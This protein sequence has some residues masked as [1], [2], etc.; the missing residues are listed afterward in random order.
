MESPDTRAYM[1]PLSGRRSAGA[2]VKK[3]LSGVVHRAMAEDN[4]RSLDTIDSGAFGASSIA[5]IGQLSILTADTAWSRAW[6]EDEVGLRHVRTHRREPHPFKT[7]WEIRC[8]YMSARHHDEC[9]VLIEEYDPSG[10]KTVPAGMCC[11]Q[12]AVEGQS[13]RGIATD[14]TSH[15]LMLEG[16]QDPSMT[17]GRSYDPDW[18]CVEFCTPGSTDHFSA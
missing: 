12:F 15:R 13:P 18:N 7:G 17:R 11:F 2:L 3:W 1:R 4:V 10:M 16:T 6:Y 14:S 8:C 5:W 9:L